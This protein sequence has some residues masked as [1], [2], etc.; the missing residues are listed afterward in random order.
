MTQ[1]R[2]KVV[3]VYRL[4]GN[5]FAETV[6]FDD[7]EAADREARKRRAIEGWVPAGGEA[8]DVSDPILSVTMRFG[9]AKQGQT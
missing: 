8:L 9:T 3:S 4:N 7:W 1:R 2:W 5:E 6:V